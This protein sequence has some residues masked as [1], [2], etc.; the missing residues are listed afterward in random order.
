MKLDTFKTKLITFLEENP[1]YK[2]LQD[3][4]N[5]EETIYRNPPTVKYNFQRIFSIVSL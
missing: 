4:A 5:S 1:A 2:D 3:Q